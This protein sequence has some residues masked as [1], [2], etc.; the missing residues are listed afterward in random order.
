[1]LY[2][3]TYTLSHQE[4]HCVWRC[5]TPPLLIYRMRVV[6]FL[7]TSAAVYIHLYIVNLLSVS[8]SSYPCYQ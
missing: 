7:A 4:L 8:Y 2:K 5:Y 6:L 3:E 1:M